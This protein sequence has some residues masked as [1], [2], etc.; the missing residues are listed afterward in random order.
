MFDEWI[1][2]IAQY[3]SPKQIVNLKSLKFFLVNNNAVATAIGVIVAYSA[4]DLIQS[5][6]GDIMLPGIYF[7]FFQRFLDNEFVS[8]MFE[9]VNRMNIPRFMKQL[10]SFTFAI[11]ITYNIIVYPVTY[12]LGDLSKKSEEEKPSDSAQLPPLPIPDGNIVYK[13]LPEV[14]GIT[15]ISESFYGR[16]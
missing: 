15:P 7:L 2:Q 12:F 14:K 9:P 16:L 11:F 8:N 6:I 1:T 13:T 5:L 3:L 10:L 4:W